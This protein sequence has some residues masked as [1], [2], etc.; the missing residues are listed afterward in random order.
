MHVFTTGLAAV[1]RRPG[2][3]LFYLV[4][5][6]LLWG[7]GG[8]TGSLLGRSAGLSAIAVAAYR[9]TAGG[10][11]IVA[12]RTLAGRPWPAG[13]AAWTRIT[14]IGLLAAL[15][16]SCYFTAV[17]LTSV[18]LATLVAIGAAP[19]VVLAAARV[20]G[21]PCGRHAAASTALAV[22]GLGLLVGLPSGFS[23]TAVL[24]SS[25]MAVLAAAG[26]AA[27]TLTSSHPVP[28]LDDLTVTGFGFTIGGLALMPLAQL[29]GGVGFRPSL[30]S[31]GLLAAL[32]TGP[33]AV[34]YTLFFRGL[35]SAAPSTAALLAL[36]EPLTGAIL[37]DL[38]LGERLSAAGIAG[39]AAIGAAVIVTVRANRGAADHVAADRGAAD[40]VAADRGAADH[41]A[42]DR[43]AADRGADRVG[44]D[45]GGDA[46]PGLPGHRLAQDHQ[47]D[48]RGQ[49]RVDAHEDAEVAGR[50]PA[51]R[52]QVERERHRRGQDPGRGGARQRGRRR[53]MPDQ[54][55]RADRQEDQ[56]RRDRGGGRP[57]STGQLSPDLPVEQDVARPAR[58]R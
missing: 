11:L 5:S 39:A 41:A 34:A 26:F 45:D 8:L 51:Q 24:A 48:E 9:L 36:L 15:Y 6:G 22:T 50:D 43:D 29:A 56:R 1:R 32:G 30:A 23:E 35:R 10:L 55:H 17:S 58:G 2:S 19:V 46:Q 20:T 4:L 57:L 21:R 54:H 44:G 27:V 12:F 14:V 37:A 28:G 16:Q 38:L 52:E 33:T 18:P 47:A 31:V 3:G 49:H 40:H 13:R 7:T 53:R 42:A 25:G